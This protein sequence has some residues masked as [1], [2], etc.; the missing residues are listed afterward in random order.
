MRARSLHVLAGAPPHAHV[1]VYLASSRQPHL[2]WTEPPQAPGIRKRRHP[3][4][5]SARD[6]CLIYAPLNFFLSF[7]SASIPRRT[8][9][10][11]LAIPFSLGIPSPGE[12]AFHLPVDHRHD[13]TLGLLHICLLLSLHSDR[14]Q[15]VNLFK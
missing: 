15:H 8:V 13:Q 4:L 12:V 11:G 7:T 5:V 3:D 2:T 6:P 10:D 1:V 9:K 14:K